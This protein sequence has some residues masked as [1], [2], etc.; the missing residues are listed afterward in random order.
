MAPLCQSFRYLEEVLLRAAG[1]RVS[2]VSVVNEKYFHRAAMRRGFKD[3]HKWRREEGWRISVCR[4]SRVYV[5]NGRLGI[6]RDSVVGVGA[7][8]LG[9]A[10]PSR[11]VYSASASMSHITKNWGLFSSI[12]FSFCAAV[13]LLKGG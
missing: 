10:E 2:G 7:M 8:Q 13:S 5:F 11:R 4:A 3:L 6:C 9:T 1:E 12:Y